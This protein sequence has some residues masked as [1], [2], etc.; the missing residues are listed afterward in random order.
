MKHPDD[1]ALVAWLDTG[2][3]ARVSRHLDGCDACLERLDALSGLGEPL[4]DGLGSAGAPPVDLVDRTTARVRD[5]VVAEEA[6]AF[7]V[8]LFALPWHVAATLVDRTPIS[9]RVVDVTPPGDNTDDDD[10]ERRDG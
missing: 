1:E 3:P 10:G 9:P 5:R 4:I 8:E 2:G 6:L 7:T